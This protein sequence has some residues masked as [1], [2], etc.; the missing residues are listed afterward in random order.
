MFCTRL[1][2]W[3]EINYQFPNPNDC[4]EWMSNFISHWTRDYLFMLGLG[5]SFNKYRQVCV[6]YSIDE[7]I[8]YHKLIV[9]I[10]IHE[11][12]AT[13]VDTLRSDQNVLI[14]DSIFEYLNKIRPVLIKTSLK[15][16]PRVQSTI[17][18]HSSDGLAANRRRTITW[19]NDDH[20]IRRNMTWKV[21][22]DL[23][24]TTV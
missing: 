14:A 8:M 6:Y 5:A 9:T 17:S 7:Y 2:V 16:V 21:P 18:H 13:K 4:I 15:Q 20:I 3:N 19:I 12:T 22:I 24:F 1:K 11:P 10:A 23:M